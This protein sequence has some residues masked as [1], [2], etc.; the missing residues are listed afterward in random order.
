MNIYQPYTYHI[1]WTS[2]NKHYYGVRFAKGC[3]PSDLWVNYFTSSKLVKE[4]RSRYGEPDII[5]IRKVF[6][7]A[8]NAKIWESKVLRKL[9]VLKSDKWLNA[10]IG[11]KQFIITSHS[12]E[13]KKKMSEN[14]FSKR[15]E[16]RKQISERQKGSNNSFYGKHHSNESKRKKRQAI[17]GI[18]RSE[19]FKDSRRGE[20]SPTK[21][22]DVRIKISEG[23][24][25][26]RANDPLTSCIICRRTFKGCSAY[27]NHRKRCN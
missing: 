19:S 17:L 18:K 23:V 27:S 7:N 10:N 13:T 5:E 4:Y 26:A 20:N 2:I 24:V 21:R 6:D 16:G 1:A 8:N 22:L 3:H 15:L 14:N 9:N 12:E 25:A 11:G